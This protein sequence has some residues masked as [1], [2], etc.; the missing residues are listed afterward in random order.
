MNTFCTFEI[1]S[2]DII[3]FEKFTKWNKTPYCKSWLHNL[4]L[5]FRGKIFDTWY[6]VMRINGAVK[7]SNTRIAR[8][9]R[10]YLCLLKCFL[11]GFLRKTLVTLNAAALFFIFRN[12]STLFISKKFRKFFS[13]QNIIKINHVSK[14]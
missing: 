10:F 14:F 8:R 6:N 5:Q 11:L 7:I 2:S 4:K 13:G 3:G 1:N 9:L 12:F